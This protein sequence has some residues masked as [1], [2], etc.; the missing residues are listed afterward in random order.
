MPSCESE[1]KQSEFN[2]SVS[3]KFSDEGL[4]SMIPM[5]SHAGHRP[6]VRIQSST[7]KLLQECAE[8]Y[9]RDS[10]GLYLAPQPGIQRRLDH[11]DVPAI[12]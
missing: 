9:D 2:E 7:L 5:A 12:P 6:I 8:V 11:E 10:N 1:L 3:Q 4:G